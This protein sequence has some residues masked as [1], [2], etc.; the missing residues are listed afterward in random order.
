MKPVRLQLS[1]KKGARLVSPNGL[2]VKIVSRPSKFTN[3][4]RLEH[5]QI[6]GE[7][8]KAK[9]KQIQREMA[10]RDFDAAL[11]LASPPNPLPGYLDFTIDDVKRELNGF[12][13]ACWCP[14]PKEGEEDHCHAAV[15]LRI[16]NE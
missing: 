6:E 15:L 2:P 12:N 7:S 16:A 8:D 14:L 5:Y 10:V 3:P 1:R 13:L 9:I 11:Y 4:Y